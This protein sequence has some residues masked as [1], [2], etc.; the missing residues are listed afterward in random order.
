MKLLKAQYQAANYEYGEFPSYGPGAKS[1]NNHFKAL[2]IN[3][4]NRRL[5]TGQNLPIHDLNEMASPRSFMSQIE[6][7]R[8]KKLDA[9]G[10]TYE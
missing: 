3:P 4:N 8:N 7:G 2:V 10:D 1:N 6:K 9:D 5:K